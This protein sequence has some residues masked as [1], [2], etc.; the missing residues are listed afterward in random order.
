VVNKK[1]LVIDDHALVREAMESALHHSCA[2]YVCSG[3]N[4]A[5]EALLRLE[6]EVDWDLA[7]LDLGLPGMNGN[8][9]LAILGKRFPDL[10]ILVVSGTDDLATIQK[11]KKA[12]ALG[13]VS[14][15]ASGQTL[16]NAVAE[17]L[18]GMLY[19]PE[20]ATVTAPKQE[21]DTLTQAQ[22]RVL[23]LL[24]Q[25]KTNR[26]IADLLNLSEGTVKQHVSAIFKVLKVSN[27]G[28]AILA[29]QKR[30]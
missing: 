21:M 22:R 27:R 6:E 5:D 13:F 28:Q 19:F 9:L 4:S 12:G 18:S 17:V 16:I 30:S 20:V 25:S 11:V 29:A 15:A 8:S 2:E 26:E 10:P 1:I 7:V 23:E 3:A 14:K 24:K